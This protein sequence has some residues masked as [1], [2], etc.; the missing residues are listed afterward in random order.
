MMDEKTLSELLTEPLRLAITFQILKSGETTAKVIGKN[1]GKPRNTVYYH[2]KKLKKAG[3]IDYREE[4]IPNRTLSQKVYRISDDFLAMKNEQEKSPKARTIPASLILRANLYEVSALIMEAATFLQNITAQQFDKIAQRSAILA[5]TYLLKESEYE[6]VIE[7]MADVL[8]MLQNY[9]KKNAK[10][11]FKR[12]SGS[13]VASEPFH[14]L[15]VVGIPPLT[16]ASA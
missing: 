11:L 14:F 8:E 12:A 9:S 16:E 1:L 3:I 5:E 4:A 7:R 13:K 15:S 2:L 6:E 10:Q